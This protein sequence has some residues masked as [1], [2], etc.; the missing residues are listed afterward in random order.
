MKKIFFLL[1]TLNDFCFSQTLAQTDKATV[2]WTA[3]KTLAKV[4]VSGD[5]SSTLYIPA[6]KQNKDLSSLM[7]GSKIIIDSTKIDTKNPARDATISEMFF[8][9]LQTTIIKGKII[10]L[11]ETKSTI[12]I[13]LQMGGITKII[14]MKYELN[15]NIF[16]AN[17]VIDILDFGGANALASISK[18]C[19]DL[20]EGKTWNDVGI[21]FQT[22]I[23]RK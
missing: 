6:Y 12:N 14:P 19:Y 17:G 9:H 5:F 21:Q 18:S 22:T 23:L 16:K 10:S 3:F 13:E 8:K 4:G 2:T 1:I 15:N 20:H 7:V 11:D